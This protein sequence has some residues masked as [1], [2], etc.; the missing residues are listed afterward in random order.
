[1]VNKKSRNAERIRRHKRVRKV[2]NGTPECP[3]L[4]VFRSNAHIYA[5]VIDDTTGN[6]LC[7]ASSLESGN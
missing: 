3:R 6:T 4:N 2:V 7:A 1:M 5:Q